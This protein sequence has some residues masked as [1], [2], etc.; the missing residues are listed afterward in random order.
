MRAPSYTRF[1]SELGRNFKL[2]TPNSK[3]TSRFKL[4]K[5]LNRSA[6]FWRAVPMQS[7]CHF[8]A[9]PL[10]IA[11]TLVVIVFAT[12]VEAADTAHG[13]LPIGKDGK[14]LNLDF[15]TGTLKDW[16]PT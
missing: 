4:Q 7:G 5:P 3:E 13:S 1:W 10:A 6:R 12:R 16:T 11:I 2:Q 14:P 8:P 9:V 15:E